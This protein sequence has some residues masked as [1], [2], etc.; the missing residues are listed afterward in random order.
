ME[1]LVAVGTAGV[2][3]VFQ[4]LSAYAPLFPELPDITIERVD[5]FM[6]VFETLLTL[7]V[8]TPV[9]FWLVVSPALLAVPGEWVKPLTIT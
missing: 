1:V 4:A 5:I 7:I 6:L 8:Y 2:P 9:E 3:V